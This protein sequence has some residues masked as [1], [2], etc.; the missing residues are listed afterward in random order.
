VLQLII[1]LDIQ[2]TQQL[3]SPPLVYVFAYVW[4]LNKDQSYVN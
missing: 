4:D 3:D 1:Q 2:T